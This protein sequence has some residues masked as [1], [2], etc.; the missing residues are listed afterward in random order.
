MSSRRRRNSNIGVTLFDDEDKRLSFTDTPVA[1]RQQYWD[2]IEVENSQQSLAVNSANRKRFQF[3]HFSKSRRLWEYLMF[4]SSSFPLIEVSFITIFLP[5]IGMKYYWPMFLFDITYIIDYFVITHT[6]YLSHGVFINDRFKI[7][8]KI[9]KWRLALHIICAIPLSW[10][11]ILIGKRWAVLTFSITRIIRV[12]RAIDAVNNLSRMLIYYSWQSIMIP[13]FFLL[14]LLIHT[15]S[16]TFYCCARLE[17]IENSWIAALGWDYLTPP[18][19]YVVSIYYVLTTILAIGFGDITPQTSVETIVVIFIQL[20]GVFSNAYI[21]GNLVS[22]LINQQRASFVGQ[23]TSLVDFLKFKM[24]PVNVRMDVYHYFQDQWKQFHGSEKPEKLYKFLPE[25]I[26]GH[27]KADMVSLCVSKIN[28]FSICT[29]KL[30]NAVINLFEEIEFIPGEAIFEQG[31]TLSELLILQRGIIEIY[32]DGRLLSTMN[33]ADGVFFGEIELLIDQPRGSTV[34]AITHVSG[35]VLYREDLQVCV[36]PR[37]DLRRSFLDVARL[38]FDRHY[39]EIR[40]NFTRANIQHLLN[41]PSD[42]GSSSDEEML[43]N[44][45]NETE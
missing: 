21:I 4:F 42:S 1:R 27:M 7:K 22:I 23:Y 18:Q 45:Q 20:I 17:G 35:W 6:S 19:L 12:I 44:L 9:G 8:K 14:F 28:M 43:G 13:L 40:K 10:I 36:V 29:T 38:L 2:S 37:F 34:K 5:T 3:T 32:V 25:T 11:G 31:E 16:C 24:I 41:L 33:C 15:F 39:T 30:K 26:R